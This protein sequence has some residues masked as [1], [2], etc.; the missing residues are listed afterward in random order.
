MLVW[1]KATLY[2]LVPYKLVKG[3][4]SDGWFISYRS[5]LTRRKPS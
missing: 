5:W 3:I 4:T 2:A 1:Y